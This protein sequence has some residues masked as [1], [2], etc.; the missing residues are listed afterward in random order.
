[1]R[2]SVERLLNANGFA[3]DGHSSADP[4]SAV[5]T[6]VRSAASSSI[7]SWVDVWRRAMAPPQASGINLSM[8]FITAVEDEVLELEVVKAGCVAYLHKPFPGELLIS[9]VRRRRTIDCIMSGIPNCEPASPKDNCQRSNFRSQTVHQL[10]SDDNTIAVEDMFRRTAG[11]YSAAFRVPSGCPS[12]RRSM[13][14]L[15]L[16]QLTLIGAFH[17]ALSLLVETAFA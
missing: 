6:S 7:S 17:T 15:S 1:M 12:G 9:A 3:T 5:P 2:R 4:F 14:W 10:S 16:W 11:T 13:K 8:I